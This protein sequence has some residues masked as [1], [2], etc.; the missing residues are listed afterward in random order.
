MSPILM[1]RGPERSHGEGLKGKE[2]TPLHHPVTER[3]HQGGG[4]ETLSPW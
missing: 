2:A 3:E 4:K 1:A